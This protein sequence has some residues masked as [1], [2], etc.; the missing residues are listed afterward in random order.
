[1]SELFQQGV[2]DYYKKVEKKSTLQPQVAMTKFFE[3]VRVE[4]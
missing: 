3:H 2:V 4:N 1:M